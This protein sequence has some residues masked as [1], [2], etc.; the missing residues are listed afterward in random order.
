MGSE[1]AFEFTSARV[2]KLILVTLFF[3]IVD[4]CFPKFDL[5]EFKRL[6]EDPPKVVLAASLF[7]VF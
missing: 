1:S 4:L 2:F 3:Y 7:F 5:C 6:L